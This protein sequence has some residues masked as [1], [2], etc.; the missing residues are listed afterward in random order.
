MVTTKP[1][2]HLRRPVVVTR[3]R[4]WTTSRKLMGNL[5]P[6]LLAA[7]P[8]AYGIFWMVR[9][10]EILGRGLGYFAISPVIGWLAMNYLGLFQNGAMRKEMAV[11]LR[12]V[13][14][15]LAVQRYFVGMATPRYTSLLDPHEDL[16]F[17]ILHSDKLE[18][19][20]DHL[21]LSIARKDIVGIGTR[22]NPHTLVGLGKWVT[23]DGRLHEHR[24]RLQIEMREK[25]T[26]FGN[27]L[28]TGKLERKLHRWLDQ[29]EEVKN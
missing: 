28:L 27:L 2:Q 9:H 25:N 22:W 7:P 29:T 8:A 1:P 18:F 5:L 21:N 23:I 10:G 14:P 16:G 20:G 15:K 26:L 3:K 24:I 13:R 19:F 12:G 11:F 17:L 4:I 6:F